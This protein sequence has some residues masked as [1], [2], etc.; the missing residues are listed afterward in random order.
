MPVELYL[1]QHDEA[2]RLIP[3]PDHPLLRTHWVPRRGAASLAAAIKSRDWS[4]WYA[5]VTPESGSLKHLRSRLRDEFG[6]PKSE[7]HAQA[8]WYHGRQMGTLRARPVPERGPATS[9]PTAGPGPEPTAEAT[10]GAVPK[11][12][13]EAGS[14]LPERVAATPTAT[15]T[16]LLRPLLQPGPGRGPGH[17]A[18]GPRDGCSPRYAPH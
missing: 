13:A 11:S 14:T 15:P 10:P 8:Y 4:D 2:D 6:F 18:R 16:A 9:E 1:E 7:V 12:T 5:W 3:L 17:G